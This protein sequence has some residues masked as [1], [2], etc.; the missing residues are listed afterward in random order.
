MT[1]TIEHR[2]NGHNK[3]PRCGIGVIIPDWRRRVCLCCGLS[4]DDV[5]TRE[6]MAKDALIFWLVRN[7]R[8]E[9]APDLSRK[10]VR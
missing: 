9:A 8:Y 4:T 7:K 2:L 6:D 1:K 5:T 10:A 3:C